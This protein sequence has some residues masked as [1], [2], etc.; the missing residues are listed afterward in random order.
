MNEKTE[1]Q[2]GAS[3]LQRETSSGETQRQEIKAELRKKIQAIRQGHTTGGYCE[4]EKLVA[5]EKKLHAILCTELE[6]LK[7]KHGYSP[8]PRFKHRDIRAV[9]VELNG[10]AFKPKLVVAHE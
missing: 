1:T 2:R 5:E 9:E 3:G 7:L 4:T 10:L 6:E 8:D